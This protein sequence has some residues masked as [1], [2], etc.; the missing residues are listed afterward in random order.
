MIHGILRGDTGPPGPRPSVL[1]LTAVST[2]IL[3]APRANPALRGPRRQRLAAA[4]DLHHVFAELR[5]HRGSVATEA[6]VA[7]G[8][9]TTILCALG[10]GFL[11][12][13][14]PKKKTQVEI[15]SEDSPKKIEKRIK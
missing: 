5:Q 4:R 14:S 7:P 10:G 1:D 13:I 9:H 8:H 12:E 3:R 2:T 15:Q 11:R 6:R